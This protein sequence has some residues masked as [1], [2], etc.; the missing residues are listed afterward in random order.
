[1]RSATFI[2]LLVFIYCAEAFV[3][4]ARHNYTEEDCQNKTGN[5]CVY[6]DMCWECSEPVLSMGYIRTK[7]YYFNN[8]TKK[9][10]EL[11]GEASYCNVFHSEDDC[12]FFCGIYDPDKDDSESRGN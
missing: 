11:T 10:D 12:E 7:V 3:H 4:I 9:C 6:P 2:T 8:L 5:P 1:M